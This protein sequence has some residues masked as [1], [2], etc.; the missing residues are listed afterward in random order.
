MESKELHDSGKES[1]E[2]HVS[3]PSTREPL[4]D[5][6]SEQRGRDIYA[7]NENYR[8]LATVMEHPEFRQF[9]ELYMNDW[10]TAK[11]VIMFMKIYEAIEKRS[12]VELTPFQKLA[13]VQD[14]IEHSET[15]QK[16]CQGMKD[17]MEQNKNLISE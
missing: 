12:S 7:T 3:N 17:W 16:V 4:L 10:D 13:I 14:V 11:T 6:E 5:A 2:L 15:R 9:Y 8:R 1:S